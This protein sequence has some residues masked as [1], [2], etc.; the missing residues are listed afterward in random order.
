MAKRESEL[1]DSIKL[2]IPVTRELADELQRW[3]TALHLTQAELAKTLLSFAL[4]DLDNIGRWLALRVSRKRVKGIKR[5]WLQRGGGEEVRLQV[6]IPASL[7][8]R[9]D[10]TADDLNHTPVRMAALLIDFAL[11]DEAWAMSLLSTKFGQMFLSL[12]GR[13]PKAYESAEMP[14]KK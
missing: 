7:K 11:A 1:D 2:Q 3:A 14:P 13:K 10:S 8:S 9:L 5:G 12:F 4:D 6:P